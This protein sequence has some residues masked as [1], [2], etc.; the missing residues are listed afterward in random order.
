MSLS[1][2]TASRWAVLVHASLAVTQSSQEQNHVW[3]LYEM[4]GMSE[5]PSLDKHI[6]CAQALARPMITSSLMH[7]A[8]SLLEME[9]L[10]NSVVLL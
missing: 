4:L 2:E 5:T 7:H 1:F 3:A 8:T 6:S 10:S 9:F